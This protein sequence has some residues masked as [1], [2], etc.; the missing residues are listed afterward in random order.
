MKI[1]RLDRQTERQWRSATGL[2]KERFYRLLS[3]FKQG[4]LEIYGNPLNSRQ[5]ASGIDYGLQSE[6]ELLLFTRFSFKSGLTNVLLIPR[7][8]KPFHSDK[9]NPIP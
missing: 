4:Y 2:N 1:N 8:K 5:V 3:Y 9:N 7:V 6:E